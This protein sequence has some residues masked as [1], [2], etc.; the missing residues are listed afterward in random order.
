M[1]AIGSS[2]DN[3]LAEAFFASLK[4]EI[5]PAHG[6][7]NTHQARL[8]V[9]RWLTFY[10]T[11]RRH[12]ALGHLSPAEYEQSRPTCSP[13]PKTA[14][15]PLPLP[16]MPS[17]TPIARS[18]LYSSSGTMA[19]ASLPSSERSSESRRSALRNHDKIK[20]RLPY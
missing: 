12:S 7:P 13:S 20:R 6:W 16:S 2:A 3:S 1:G 15:R 18:R 19:A 11:R 8:E 4:R 17:R 10:N 14:S 9:F 5:L